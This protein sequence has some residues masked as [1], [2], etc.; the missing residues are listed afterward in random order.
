VIYRKSP[1]GLAVPGILAKD[2]PAEPEKLNRLLQELAWEAA[3]AHP[4]SGV[5]R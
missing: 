3:V 1:V 2:K 4:L 5:K